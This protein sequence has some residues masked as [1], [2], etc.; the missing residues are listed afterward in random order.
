[1]KRSDRSKAIEASGLLTQVKS[2]QFLLCL[3]LFKKIFNATAKLSN[4]YQGEE[5]NFTAAATFIEATINTLKSF[6]TEDNKGTFMM[7]QQL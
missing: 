4:V 7:R 1:M 2:L 6:R 5:L 3:Q